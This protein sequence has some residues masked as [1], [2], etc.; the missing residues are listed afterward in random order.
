MAA[1]FYRTKA[2]H[3]TAPAPRPC[4]VS[5][6]RR[7]RLVGSRVRRFSNWVLPVRGDMTKWSELWAVL[8]WRSADHGWRRKRCFCLECGVWFS[9]SLDGCN[10]GSLCCPSVTV[11]I[12]MRVPLQASPILEI[13]GNVH[14]LLVLVSLLVGFSAQTWE[15]EQI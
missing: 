13:S 4:G 5:L 9:M 2:R 8:I 3:S 15:F 1:K 11:Q 10:A 14:R 7:I 12:T 6:F